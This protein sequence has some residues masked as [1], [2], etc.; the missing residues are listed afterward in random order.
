MSLL[1]EQE[2]IVDY[3]MNDVLNL[4][5]INSNVC[6]DNKYRFCFGTKILEINNSFFSKWNDKPLDYL[7]VHNIPKHCFYIDPFQS[8]QSIPVLYGDQSMIIE[9]DYI[10]CG[11]DIFASAFFMLTRWEEL[12]INKKDQYG[13]CDE[14]EM[15]VVREGIWERPIVNEYIRLLYDFLL[16]LGVQV[17]PCSHIFT[18]YLTHDIDDLFRYTSITNLVKNIA[19]DIL[20][21]KSLICLGTTLK[22]Y[23]LYRCGKIKDPFDTFDWLMDLSDQHGFKNAFY[24]K[25]AFKKEY[26]ATYDI[27]DKKVIDIIN[28]ILRRN[29]EVGFH[30]S[31]NTFHNSK[32]Y[33]EEVKR[34]KDVFPLIRGGR[35]HFLLY[36]IPCTMREWDNNGFEYDAGL[37]FA[38]RAGFRCGIC[39][40]YPFFD[41]CKREKLN[42]KIRP[43]IVMEAALIR[44]VSPVDMEE[45]MKRLAK[46]VHYYN[47]EYVFLWHNDNFFRPEVRPYSFVYENIVEYLRILVNK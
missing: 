36:D 37:G 13:R 1:P 18:P 23:L 41:V 27:R 35:Q 10:Y 31:K 19:G 42:L 34:L 33:K 47:G 39:Y 21:R 29:H 45:C 7:H 43:L 44:R 2:Y 16:H 26:D 4:D 24:F 30:P 8:K 32:Q 15:L 40:E 11:A 3:L 17:S 9:E 20:H 6:L 46:I 14:S 12:V 25:A 22:S 28:N 38:F 5:I